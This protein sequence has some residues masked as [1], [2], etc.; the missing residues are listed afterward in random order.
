VLAQWG[1][2]SSRERLDARSHW[3]DRRLAALIAHKRA[4]P[5]DER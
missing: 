4:Q 5:S 3:R 2:A 1:Q